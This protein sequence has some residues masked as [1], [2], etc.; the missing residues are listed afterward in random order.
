MDGVRSSRAEPHFPPSP[1]ERVPF[2]PQRKIIRAE[3]K[4]ASTAFSVWSET[5]WKT[6]KR[7]KHDKTTETKSTKWGAVCRLSLSNV[8]IRYLC[9]I[10]LK[11][12]LSPSFCHK[13]MSCRKSASHSAIPTFSTR[14]Q[15]SFL[16][17][18][19]SI[20]QHRN[21]LDD[22]KNYNNFKCIS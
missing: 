22:K 12:W 8:A 11:W 19:H 15:D 7:A 4:Q 17:R 16:Q 9:P 18:C 13:S 5:Q 14:G 20:S 6:S 1:R 21:T 10:K 3:E 2:T